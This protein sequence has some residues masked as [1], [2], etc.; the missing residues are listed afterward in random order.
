MSRKLTTKQRDFVHRVAEGANPSQAARDAGYS[1]PNQDA[2]KLMRV[3]HVL[4]AIRER[5]TAEIDGDLTTIALDTMRELMTDAESVPASTRYKA[6][7]WTL[8]AAGYAG[9]EADQ[10][11]DAVPLEEMNAAQLADAVSSGMQ[12]LGELAQQLNGSHVIDNQV[13]PLKQISADVVEV[14]DD[15]LE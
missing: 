9:R 8:K 7:E 13:R 15:F 6:A 11:P 3:P 1:A 4:Q 12:A 14:T 2:Y 5:R 10:G